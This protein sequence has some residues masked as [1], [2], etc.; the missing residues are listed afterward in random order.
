[1]IDNGK[2]ST[3]IISILTAFAAA[4]IADPTILGQFGIPA[5]Y[6]SSI[7]LVIAIIYNALYPRNT[8]TPINT[9]SNTS[10]MTTNSNGILEYD[11]EGA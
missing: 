1:M 10:T 7:A 6:I 5:Q 3:I 2:L 11:D 9:T 8:Q 4:V